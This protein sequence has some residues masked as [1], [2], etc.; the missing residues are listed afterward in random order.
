[1]DS[2]VKWSHETHVDE[3]TMIGNSVKE[4]ICIGYP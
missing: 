3:P 2:F 4:H 1:M